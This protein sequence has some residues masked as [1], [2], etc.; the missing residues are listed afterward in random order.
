MIIQRQD[1]PISEMF[2]ER[3]ERSTVVNGAAE[4]F[5]VVG[6]GLTGFTRPQHIVS[7]G[8]KP[9]CKVNA[10]HLVEVQSHRPLTRLRPE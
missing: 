1:G 6:R 3:E 9:F 4:Y 2:V 10:E 8:A 7:V 5:R